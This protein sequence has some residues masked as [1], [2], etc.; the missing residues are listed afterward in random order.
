MDNGISYKNALS[1]ALKI[2]DID[3]IESNDILGI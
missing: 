3:D 1:K 2:Y